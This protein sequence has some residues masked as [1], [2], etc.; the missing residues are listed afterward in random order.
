MPLTNNKDDGL[1][2]VYS[3][4]TPRL[5]FWCTLQSFSQYCTVHSVKFFYLKELSLSHHCSIFSIRLTY[6]LICQIVQFSIFGVY[7]MCSSG[8]DMNISYFRIYIF[9]VN[10]GSLLVITL[11]RATTAKQHFQTSFDL[12][13][14]LHSS[15]IGDSLVDH[16]L[17]QYLY[18]V[19][20]WA[21]DKSFATLVLRVTFNG[22]MMTIAPDAA[23][24]ATFIVPIILLEIFSLHF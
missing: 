9:A 20:F 10:A 22:L 1:R 7:L 13:H 23:I 4:Y 21:L 14:A 11:S 18:F 2:V 3:L 5:L 8:S 16:G 17:K 19:V 6:R 24:G 15:F 12:V